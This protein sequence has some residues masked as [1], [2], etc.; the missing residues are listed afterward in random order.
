[1]KEKGYQKLERRKLLEFWMT[2]SLF[3]VEEDTD[4]KKKLMILF[5]ENIWK[6]SKRAGQYQNPTLFTQSWLE[7]IFT[8]QKKPQFCH[9][10]IKFEEGDQFQKI[11]A[12]QQL[13]PIQRKRYLQE[14]KAIAEGDANTI[15]VTQDF[16]QLELESGFVQD[17][18][19]CC[20]WYDEESKDGLGR[21]YCHFVGNNYDMGLTIDFD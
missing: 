11:I 13:I 7:N 21:E 15:L 14:K 3:K 9:H 12:H 20:Y 17:L 6:M 19:I 8:I 2:F 4:I 16:T 18:I 1:M 10:C 5:T